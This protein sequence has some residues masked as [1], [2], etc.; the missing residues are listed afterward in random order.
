MS[1]GIRWSDDEYR[2]YLARTNRAR[3]YS[4]DAEPSPRD[5]ISKPIQREENHPRYDLRIHQKRRRLTDTDAVAYKS[6]I[7]GLV[8]G[9]I[10]RDDS[11]SV[12]R[13]IS[14]TQE[15]CGRCEDEETVIEIY[16]VSD[17][18]K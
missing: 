12:I 18:G 2:A 4:P 3:L 14:F 13:T 11:A 8:K 15:K 6:A 17:A 10:L 9:E 5:G 7:D 1:S 16:E